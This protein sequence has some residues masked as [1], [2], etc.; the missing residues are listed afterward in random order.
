MIDRKTTGGYN[1]IMS[2]IRFYSMGLKFSYV[3]LPEVSLKIFKFGSFAYSRWLPKWPDYAPNS[4]FSS[5]PT[6]SDSHYAGVSP[7]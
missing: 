3:S 2:W 4:I 1:V 6:E 5:L 7:V